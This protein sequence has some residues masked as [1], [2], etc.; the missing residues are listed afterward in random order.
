[1]KQ[2]SES[3]SRPKANS[4]G[5][6]SYSSFSIQHFLIEVVVWAK[7]GYAGAADDN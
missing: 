6:F 3:L 7:I 4:E 2:L 5:H 1:M